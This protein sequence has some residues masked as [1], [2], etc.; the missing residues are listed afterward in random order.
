MGAKEGHRFFIMLLILSG[1]IIAGLYTLFFAGRRVNVFLFNHF[2]VNKAFVRSLPKEYSGEK[3]E[4]IRTKLL[5]FFDRA[6]RSCPS[7]GST[8]CVGDTR[9]FAVE[10]EIQRAMSDDRLTDEEVQRILKEVEIDT[11]ASKASVRGRRNEASPVES[12]DLALPVRARGVGASEEREANRT[13]PH[14]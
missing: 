1:L 11:P 7:G 9:L 14:R 8:Q 13:G 12:E 4:E 6:R 5:D 10:R 3:I 2:V